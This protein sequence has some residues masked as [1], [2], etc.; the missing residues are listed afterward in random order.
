MTR[1]VLTLGLAGFAALSLF[2][3]AAAQTPAPSAAKKE[4]VAR[5]LAAQQGPIEGV[6]HSVVDSPAAQ[7][8]R[9]AGMHIQQTMQPDKRE[10]AGRAVEAEVKKYVDE[11]YPLV[12]D[13]ALKIAPTTMGSVLE[14]KLTEEELKVYVT[15]LESPTNKKVQQLSGEVM[16]GF[17]QQLLGEVRPLL[18]PKLAALDGRVRV[19]LGLPAMP[20]RAATSP[21]SASR[22]GGK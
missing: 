11:A 9:E 1:R 5:V 3:T 12:R 22:P 14:S 20:Q 10:A 13:R 16:S 19:A 15:W 18:Q 4:L 7:M 21:A 17:V 2:T 8:M 6:A